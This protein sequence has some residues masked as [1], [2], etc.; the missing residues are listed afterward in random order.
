MTKFVAIFIGGGIGSVF[1]FLVSLYVQKFKVNHSFPLATLISNGLAC[2]IMTYFLWF[3]KGKNLSSETLTF[4]IITGI[5]GGFSTF[6]TFS[7]ENYLL[8][9]QGNFLVMLA[10]IL[11]SLILGFGL[12]YWVLKQ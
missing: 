7:Y 2:L 1:R 4:F 11:I 10:N 12:F 6:S 8:A 9:Q 5:C 3:M